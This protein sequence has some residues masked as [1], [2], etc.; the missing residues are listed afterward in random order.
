[1]HNIVHLLILITLGFFLLSWS[2]LFAFSYWSYRS[3]LNV[4]LF[5]DFIMIEATAARIYF[6]TTNF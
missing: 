6:K 5:S 3:S 1:M 2:K 4:V